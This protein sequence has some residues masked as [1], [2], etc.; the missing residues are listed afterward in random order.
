MNLSSTPEQEWNIED[1]P[2]EI[3][4]TSQHISDAVHRHLAPEE[5]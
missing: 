2:F 5:D 1:L 3:V 4:S